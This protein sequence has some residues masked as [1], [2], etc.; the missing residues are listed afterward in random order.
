MPPATIVYSVSPSAS[1]RVADRARD[2]DV[3]LRGLLALRLLGRLVRLAAA[4]RIPRALGLRR[5]RGGGRGS[6]GGRLG[7]RLGRG[8]VGRRSGSGR[9]RRGRVGV[10]VAA[11][12]PEGSAASV[13]S[14]TSTIS[15][16][17]TRRPRSPRPAPV[18]GRD[19]AGGYADVALHAALQIEPWCRP[20]PRIASEGPASGSRCRR[21]ASTGVSVPSTT[22]DVLR[23]RASPSARPRAAAGRRT[24]RPAARRRGLP[25]ASSHDRR[26]G[27]LPGPSRTTT[28]AP[29]TGRGAQAGS[30]RDRFDRTRR[31]GNGGDRQAR[32]GSTTAPARS[33][34]PQ[35]HAS[36]G[37]GDRDERPGRRWV[38][39][40]RETTSRQVRFPSRRRHA[41]LARNSRD[42]ASET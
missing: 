15:T 2:R 8:R 33:A 38:L 25:L 6:G 10:S 28:V 13:G 5:R 39:M 22:V 26:D 1:V 12:D 29:A 24:R 14:A 34:P 40:G 7:G 37:Q 20:A 32:P 30:R 35:A 3:D 9:R 11:G 4:R 19:M 17:S 23:L 41:M 21:R 36:E 42:R 31:A 18:D 16:A 27:L